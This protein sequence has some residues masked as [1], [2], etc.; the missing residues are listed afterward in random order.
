MSGVNLPARRVIF[1]NMIIGIE[2]L[3]GARYKQMAGRAGRAG[4]DSVGE[5]FLIVEKYWNAQR[6]EKARKL[7]N[8]PLP[9]LKSALSL[10]STVHVSLSSFECVVLDVQ[11]F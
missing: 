9:P 5:S 8:E 2:D 10:V 3:D 4:K 7:I 11:V 1:R 6:R